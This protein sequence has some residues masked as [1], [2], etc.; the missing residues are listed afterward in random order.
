[1]NATA[2]QSAEPQDGAERIRLEIIEASM[3]LFQHY[4]FSKTTMADIARA[5]SMSPG[6][7]YRYYKNKQ[8]IGRA[9]VERYFRMSEAQMETGLM[10][11]GGGP[12][13]RIRGLI[14]DG[15]GHLMREMAHNPRLVELADFICSDPEGMISLQQHV[16]WK[17]KAIA[18]EVVR[19]IQTGEFKP[20]DAEQ[21]GQI[22]VAATRAYWMP[23]ALIH[24]R[25]EDGKPVLLEDIID[26]ML[27]G[28]RPSK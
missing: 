14:S 10:L 24:I 1:M 17:E 21:V 7:L 28:L 12:A 13:E 22:F 6:N 2:K 5:T 4:G 8:D 18:K 26:L 11:P 3:V 27:A 19:G 9:V 25:Q 20:C 15:V 16:E 23:M